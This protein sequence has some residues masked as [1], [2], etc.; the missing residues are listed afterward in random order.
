MYTFL[1]ILVLVSIWT[2]SAYVKK[3][4]SNKISAEQIILIISFFAFTLIISYT[5]AKQ[6]IFKKNDV[7][8]NFFNNENVD[9][10]IL[11][12]LLSLSLLGFVASIINIYLL[13]QNDLSLISPLIHSSEIILAMFVGYFFLN[14]NLGFTNY[15]G[16]I[17]IIC[18]II[19]IES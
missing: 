14:E 13:N 18:G 3:T 2:F 15:I 11:L 8:I 9:Y 12:K 7:Y 17:L 19:V 5:L 1:L 10:I 16:A 6:Y 4:V